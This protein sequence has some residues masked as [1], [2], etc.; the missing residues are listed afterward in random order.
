MRPRRRV[1]RRLDVRQCGELHRNA[2][3]RE[4]HFDIGAPA[5]GPLEPVAEPVLQA[6]LMADVSRCRDERLVTYAVRPQAEDARFLGR[7]VVALPVREFRE[8]RLYLLAPPDDFA[9]PFAWPGIRRE[10]DALVD[11]AEVPCVVHHALIRRVFG[12]DAHPEIDVGL[13]FRGL[14]ESLLG[15]SARRPEQGQ[16]APDLTF[17]CH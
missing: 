11:D 17:A 7:Q 1:I 2:E 10:I 16:Q 15:A 4:F 8:H 3:R 9:P 6:L 12:K 14:R 13:Q 5:A